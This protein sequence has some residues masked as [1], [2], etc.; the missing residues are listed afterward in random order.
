MA[1]LFTLMAPAPPALL[2]H[3]LSLDVR[4]DIGINPYLAALVYCARASS[5]DLFSIRTDCRDWRVGGRSNALRLA[6]I[7][8]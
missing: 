1:R 7:G 4:Q 8:G 6:A 3:F 2:N 5:C